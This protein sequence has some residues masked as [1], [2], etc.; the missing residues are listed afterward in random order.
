MSCRRYIATHLP[1]QRKLKKAQKGDA[2][3]AAMKVNKKLLQQHLTSSTGKAA[4]LRKLT[5]M[6]AE[7]NTSSSGNDFDILVMCL[8]WLEGTVQKLL[9]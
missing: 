5:N 8:R 3:Q 2:S 4:T 9:L 7:L 1:Q 6:Q